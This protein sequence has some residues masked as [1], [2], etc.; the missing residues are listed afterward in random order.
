MY[1]NRLLTKLGKNSDTQDSPT[2]I[3]IVMFE[4]RQGQ[5]L[6]SSSEPNTGLENCHFT[7]FILEALIPSNFDIT[8][9]CNQRL[10]AKI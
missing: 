9:L 3:L 1:V 6:N 2:E 10:L 5:F 7:M 8:V 4:L